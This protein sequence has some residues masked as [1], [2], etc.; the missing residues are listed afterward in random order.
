MQVALI[1][2]D[3][4][5]ALDAAAP[6]ALAGLRTVVAT[7]L[8]GL[9]LALA[10]GAEVIAVST[11]SREGT[12]AEAA[13]R[14]GAAARALE[15]APW[16]MKKIDSRLK[17]WVRAETRAVLDATGQVRVL[18]APAIPALGR[19]VL[20]GAVTGHGL[21]HPLPLAPHLPSGPGLCILCPDT[22]TGAD[23]DRALSAE[24]PD[25]LL[26]GARGLAEAL[27]RRLGRPGMRPVTRLPGPVLTLIGSR[28]PITL[29]QLARLR[30]AR[31]DVRHVTAPNGQADLAGLGGDAVLQA[32]PAHEV[33]PGAAVAARLAEAAR[34]L[35][36]QAGTLVLT[37]GETAQAVLDA[38]GITALD[39]LGEVEPA[40]PVSRPLG[41]GPWPLIVTKSGGLG[42]GDALL[43]PYRD[44][45]PHR[46]DG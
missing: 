35:A 2:D 7:G 16:R 32:V 6:L 13:R 22:A 20:G 37:G 17:G 4:T 28:D 34:D 11:A 44:R 26:V 27:A 19:T 3:L 30:A 45:P 23:M 18:M 43:H 46:P 39:L 24:G 10:S 41:P 33:L 5:G 31:P 36:P 1:A 9:P 42:S 29:A 15:A 40:M 12:E 38:L 25:C 8:A 14:A 21:D